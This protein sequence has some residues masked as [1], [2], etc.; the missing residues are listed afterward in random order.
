MNTLVEFKSVEVQRGSQ[1][2]FK[3]LNFSI[4]K[5]EF[6][7]VIGP[8]G[9]GKSTLARCILDLMKVRS[10]TLSVKKGVRMGYVPQNL[11]PSKTFPI[12]VKEFLTLKSSPSDVA[13]VLQSLS[14]DDVIQ[15]KRL[16]D[17][18]P[19]WMQKIYLAFALL[20]SPDLLVLDE[21]TDG[22]DSSGQVQLFELLS[23]LRAKNAMTS[24]VITHDISAVT[25]KASRA[26]CLGHGEL[27]FDGSPKDENFHSCLH[28]IYGKESFIHEHS[29]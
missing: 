15:D 24:V 17:L 22:L 4:E 3:N 7:F 11:I 20:S 18:S 27:L 14:I 26:V 1:T 8:N 10:G 9:S 12:S 2:L 25:K 28:K 23:S 5:G 13:S 19:G 29:H 16:K 21:V 6:L